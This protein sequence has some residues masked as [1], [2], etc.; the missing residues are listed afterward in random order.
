MSRKIEVDTK[1]FV[2]F[3]L[4]IL[5]MALVA[6]FLWKAATGLLIVGISIFLAVA[7]SPMVTRVAKIIPGNRRKVATAISY[8]AVV[9]IL[10]GIIAVV[11]PVIVDETVKFMANLPDTLDNIAGSFSWINDIGERIGIENFQ[12]E[13][14]TAVENFSA[15]FVRDLGGGIINSVGVVSNML[16]MA[17]LTLFLTFFIL[18]DGPGLLDKLWKKHEKNEKVMRAQRVVGKMASVVAKFVSGALSVALINSLMTAAV[19]FVLSLIFNF[20]PGLALPFGLVTGLFSIIP[21]FGSLIGG[22]LVSI[23]LA[24]GGWGAGLA[25]F[26]YYIVYLQFEANLITP[27]VQGRG[28]KLPALVILGAVTIGVY[29]WGLLGA[30]VA[31]PIVGCIKVIIE[32]YGDGETS[33]VKIAG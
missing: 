20:S 7:I 11:V 16:A 12:G 10:V 31:I 30:I 28:L 26:V 17:I 8:V 24:F 15:D 5:G 1:T 27:R 2:R 21:M 25:F 22:I 18:I 3:W 33:D 23:L 6:L 4:V 14:V 13:I 29:M 9:A 19:V 32:E